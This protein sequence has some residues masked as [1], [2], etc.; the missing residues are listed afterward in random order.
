MTPLILADSNALGHAY[1][2][3]MKLTVG[4]FQTQAIFGV[5]KAIQTYA[6]VSPES[7]IFA[8]WDGEASFRKELLP[9]YKA[10]RSEA[11][12]ADPEAMKRREAYRKQIPILKKGLEL[13]GVPQ[14]LVPDREADDIA[15]AIVADTEPKGQKV[16]LITGDSDWLQLVGEHTSWI[17]PR[18]E[19]KKVT[20]E[21]FLEMTGYHTPAEYLQG[22]CLV[23]DTADNIPGVGGIGAKGAPLL[24]AQ[25]RSIKNFWV[26]CETG[27]Y[28]PT[29]KAEIS[30]WKG[31]GRNNFIRNLKLMKLRNPE[32]PTLVEI[33]RHTNPGKFQPDAFKALCERLAFMSILKNFD[34]FVKPFADRAQHLKA[35]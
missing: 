27:E 8:F 12:A 1:H 29:K 18:G 26:R 23:G 7:S 16:T 14:I 19:G 34:A 30:L 31:P 21:N 22:K 24:L 17:D 13:L 20:L 15:G 2:N 28:K 11:L 6:S 33:A 25:F 9:E 5:I 32:R 3:A 4:D 10:N 35:E